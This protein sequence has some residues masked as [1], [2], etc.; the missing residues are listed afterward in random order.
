L[1]QAWAGQAERNRVTPSRFLAA[2]KE[3]I[4]NWPK[5]ERRL[6]TQ[7]HELLIRE[8]VAVSYSLLYR[9]AFKHCDFGSSAVTM[10]RTE[11]APGEVAEVDFGRLGFD[12]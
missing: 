11:S 2:E 4:E 3:Q 5:K 6:L 9:F 8:G 7:V 10:R 1:V 12:S